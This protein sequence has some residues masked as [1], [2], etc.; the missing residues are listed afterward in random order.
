MGGVESDLLMLSLKQM[1]KPNHGMDMADIMVDMDIHM[2]MPDIITLENDLLMP[3]QNQKQKPSHGM[4]MA[5]MDMHIVLMDMDIVDT[6]IGVK[7]S[8]HYYQSYLRNA[9]YFG[10]FFFFF[11]EYCKCSNFV[12]SSKIWQINESF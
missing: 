4:D 8:Y 10:I 12:S 5:V 6:D 11:L 7:P 2:V 3:N 1:L 9:L